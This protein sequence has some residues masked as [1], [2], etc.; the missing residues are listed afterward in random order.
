MIDNSV[1]MRAPHP[2]LPSLPKAP[3]ICD[4]SHDENEKLYETISLHSLNKEDDFEASVLKGSLSAPV[5][6]VTQRGPLATPKGQ[7]V[8]SP[9]YLSLEA[10]SVKRS[11]SIG[12]A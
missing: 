11:T 9:I 3:V 8:M 12:E 1:A 10:E 5:L 7:E 2:P 6:E 4:V